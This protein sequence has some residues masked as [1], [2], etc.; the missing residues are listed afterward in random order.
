MPVGGVALETGKAIAE[1]LRAAL[2]A[3]GANAGMGA[4]VALSAV[5]M[6]RDQPLPQL[7]GAA[8]AALARAENQGP[9]SVEHVPADQIRTGGSAPRGEAAWRQQIIDALDHQRAR[10]IAFPLIDA[11]S[12][13]IHLDCPLRLQFES[14][15]E[16]VAAA[17]WMPMAR[18]GHVTPQVDERAVALALQAIEADRLARCVNLSAA[19]LADSAFVAR[20]RIV[21]QERREAARLLWLDI[22]EIAAV[23][24]FG[25]VQEAARQLRTVGARVGLEHAGERLGRIKQLLDAGLDYVKLDASMVRGV[26]GDEGRAHHL[27]SAIAMLHGL[28][29]QAYAEGVENP[30]DA[31]RLWQLGIDGITGP[32][33]SAQREDLVG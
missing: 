17:R 6:A 23:E 32:W 22:P 21:L 10:L 31:Q 11:S 33:A 4:A 27:R 9:F 1:A 5:E 29:M 3:Y 12:Q 8:D 28:S 13:L 15:G 25:Q 30:A 24:R 19:S 26:A 2:P 16:F 18:R 14:E 7:L 20:L